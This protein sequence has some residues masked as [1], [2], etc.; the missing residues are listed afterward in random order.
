MK[1][2]VTLPLEIAH[3]ENDKSQVGS[4]KNLSIKK[5]FKGNLN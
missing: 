3:A 1:L 2:L 5:E 4:N